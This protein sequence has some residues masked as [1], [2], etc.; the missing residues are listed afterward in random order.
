MN[1]ISLACKERAQ[2]ASKVRK[3]AH[4]FEPKLFDL[5]LFLRNEAPSTPI[6]R[7]SNDPACEMRKERQKK[8]EGK[9]ERKEEKCGIK[10]PKEKKKKKK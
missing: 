9:R 6:K 3:K 2:K 10:S 1:T 8:R 5:P 4:S 7:G